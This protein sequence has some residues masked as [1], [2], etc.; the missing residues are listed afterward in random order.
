MKKTYIIPAM[1]AM[2]VAQCL[3][4][5]GSDG[6]LTKNGD[7]YT[8]GLKNQNAT[9]AGLVKDNSYDVWDDDWSK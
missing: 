3:P 7:N 2:K 4:I 6:D 9:G 5:A 1:E 8:G